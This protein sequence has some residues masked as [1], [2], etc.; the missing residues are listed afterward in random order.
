MIPKRLRRIKVA[1]QLGYKSADNNRPPRAWHPNS[2]KGPQNIG[3]AQVQHP[4][5]CSAAR[6]IGLGQ[7]SCDTQRT[8]PKDPA[9]AH[10]TRLMLQMM[11]LRLRHKQGAVRPRPCTEGGRHEGQVGTA[12]DRG[13]LYGQL[14]RLSTKAH[15]EGHHQLQCRDQ[16]L[17]VGRRV[18]A[19][20]G[21][22]QQYGT[23][24]ATCLRERRRVA[25]RSELA[26]H[27]GTCQGGEERLQIRRRVAWRAEN[28]TSQRACSAP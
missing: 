3:S 5:R 14:G 4:Y 21:Y 11:A 17:R 16:R 27:H 20:S 6:L 10:I 9:A 15:G 24:S 23:Q 12:F 8:Q 13:A 22:V 1:L 28:G 7:G 25:T 26:Q 19:H 2:P 18:A